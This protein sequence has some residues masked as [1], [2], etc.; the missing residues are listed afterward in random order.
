VGQAF[1]LC[2]VGAGPPGAY[3]I[4]GDG[5]LTGADVVREL[6]LAPV[7][8]PPRPLHAAAR[9]LARV[10]VPAFVP[11]VVEWIEA[12]GHPSIMDASKAK[13]ELGWQPRYTS[14]QALRDMLRM[15]TRLRP[16]RGPRADHLQAP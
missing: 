10:P 5:V 11:P 13:H 4:T 12:L 1:V 7:A 2:I 3:N 15:R 6:G 9:A 16:A 14:L 8:V